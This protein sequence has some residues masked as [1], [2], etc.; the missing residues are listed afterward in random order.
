[1]LY[2]IRPSSKNQVSGAQMNRRISFMLALIFILTACSANETIK[3]NSTNDRLS[4]CPTSPNC[5]SS[6]SEDKSH[7][8][9]PLKYNGTPEEAREKLISVI[10][11]MKRSEIVTAE[12]NFIHATF[13]STLF[14]F[15]DDVEF[16]FD[17][18]RKVIDVRS[19]S[20][21]GCSDLGVNRK[22]VEE[23]RKRFVNP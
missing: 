10:N 14:G 7:Y 22:R 17:D 16:S 11:S 20:R 1:M 19:A 9:E 6:L 4:P 3:T 18:Q 23:I 12:M 15:V 5:V 2:A 13:K 21:T 8:V